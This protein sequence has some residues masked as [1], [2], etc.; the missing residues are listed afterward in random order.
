MKKLQEQ[1]RKQ[2]EEAL[3]EQRMERLT[4]EQNEMLL[5]EQQNQLDAQ[6]YASEDE[7]GGYWGGGDGI[8]DASRGYLL[9]S[10]LTPKPLPSFRR[11]HL[12]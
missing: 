1:Q 12:R 9:T 3:M 10:K 5:S 7:H 6:F 2:D 11:R 8:F 4:M